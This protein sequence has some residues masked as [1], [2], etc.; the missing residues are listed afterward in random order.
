MAQHNAR[1]LVIELSRDR[2]RRIRGRVGYDALQRPSRGGGVR[3]VMGRGG[4]RI[5]AG[6]GA[7][8]R[9]SGVQPVRDHVLEPVYRIEKWTSRSNHA[10][11]DGP[12]PSQHGIT[13]GN[14][15]Y[16]VEPSGDLFEFFKG[17]DT[18]FDSDWDPR[19]W[20]PDELEAGGVW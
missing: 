15:M 2:S 16:H 18:I 10:R 9:F 20:Y 19:T 8:V 14:F 13:Q 6:T 12:A 1:P 4:P 3:R 11:P 5:P 17:Y 7:P